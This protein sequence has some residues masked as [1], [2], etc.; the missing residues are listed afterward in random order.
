MACQRTIFFRPGEPERSSVFSS[1]RAFEAAVRDQ[2]AAGASRHAAAGR[3]GPARPPARARTRRP[4]DQNFLYDPATDEIRA[5]G[6]PGVV[7]PDPG[8]LPHLP[9][10]RPGRQPQPRTGRRDGPAA[11]EPAT[12]TTRRIC[13]GAAKPQA[14]CNVRCPWL[15]RP[16]CPIPP[17]TSTNTTIRLITRY[18][19]PR[20]ERDLE[21]AAEVQHLAAALGRAGRGRGGAGAADHA[22]ADR[23]A[24]ARTSTTSTS[25]RP[26][27]YER[28]LRH[29]VMAHVHAYGDVCPTARPI[30]H[31]GATSCYVTDN[32]DLLHDA[33]G[34]ACW[35]AT[36]WS[37]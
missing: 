11:S 34:A 2:L 13:D 26:T 6:R 28:E 12:R 36:G 37:A 9:H 35:S 25:R 16:Q 22:R 32:T 10:L 4:P 20:D 27:R 19:S 17:W 14:I 23:R 24:R 18:A 31:L 8:Q 1:T 21:P 30:I 33:R 15:L 5:A 29:D 7:P 3:H